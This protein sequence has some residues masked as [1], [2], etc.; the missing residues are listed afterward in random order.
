[1]SVFCVAE[2]NENLSKLKNEIEIDLSREN[3]RGLTPKCDWHELCSKMRLKE[4][5][6]K[7]NTARNYE[8]MI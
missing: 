3:K 6:I 1:M 4:K 7:A 8:K 5:R 2:Q